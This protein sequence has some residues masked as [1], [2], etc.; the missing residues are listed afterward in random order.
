MWVWEKGKKESEWKCVIESSVRKSF[1]LQT[2]FRRV[3][4]LGCVLY[5]GVAFCMCLPSPSVWEAMIHSPSFHQGC[6]LWSSPSHTLGSPRCTQPSSGDQIIKLFIFFGFYT[7]WGFQ[8]QKQI[9]LWSNTCGVPPWKC[10]PLSPAKQN[11]VKH[12][13]WYPA[14]TNVVQ[15]YSKWNNSKSF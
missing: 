10:C 7:I 9:V 6:K 8:P 3:E 2:A 14:R 12:V 13:C 4:R 1:I 5:A 15:P 11:E